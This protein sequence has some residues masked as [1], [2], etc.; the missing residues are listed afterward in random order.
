MQQRGAEVELRCGGGDGGGG[1]E[2]VDLA[3]DGRQGGYY[4]GGAAWCELAVFVQIIPES[5][6]NNAA[7]QS[8]WK[9]SRLLV[10]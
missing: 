6:P 8:D 1:G 7:R 4:D 10:G 5:Q 2:A 9:F 3:E